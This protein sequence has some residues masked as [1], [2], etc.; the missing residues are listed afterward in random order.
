MTPVEYKI[1]LSGRLPFWFRFRFFI[2]RYPAVY[3]PYSRWRYPRQTVDPSKVL[4]IEG[5]CRSAS[6]FAAECFRH[7]NGF[8]VKLAWN[9]HA[10]GAV[11]YAKEQGIPVLL[12]IRKPK[13]TVISTKLMNPAL[14]FKV[15]LTQYIGYYKFL[16]RC[17]DHMVV[18]TRDQVNE[19]FG[20]VI[21]RLNR[22]FAREFKVFDHTPQNHQMV[23]D[24]M[25]GK[26]NENFG[27]SW[28]DSV[29]KTISW[30]TEDKA[31]M[32]APLV[33]EYNESE[34]LQNLEQEAEKIF[35]TYTELS[36]KE[37]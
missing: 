33:L 37:F 2:S 17:R 31:Q 5:F 8:D 35:A 21:E 1:S 12:M 27:E 3:Q 22:R 7:A 30:P 9:M 36:L 32:R 25:A 29:R 16:Y 4:L 23:L 18:A 20:H 6:S 15:I 19:D 10:P 14:P 11:V 28:T 13:D 34:E 26:V 24:Y